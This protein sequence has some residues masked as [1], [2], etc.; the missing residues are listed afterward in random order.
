MAARLEG[1]DKKI[2]LHSTAALVFGSVTNR[3]LQLLRRSTD[4]FTELLN[5]EVGL[6]GLHKKFQ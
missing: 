1:K 5:S 3:R 6:I 2:L 4:G